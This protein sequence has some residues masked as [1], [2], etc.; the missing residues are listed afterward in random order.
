MRKLKLLRKK[1]MWKLILEI[2]RTVLISVFL[3]A[4]AFGSI[5]LLAWLVKVVLV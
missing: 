4:V 1:K 3:L 2:L 5:V